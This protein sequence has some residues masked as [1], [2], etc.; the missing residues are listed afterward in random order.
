MY[1]DL[2]PEKTPPPGIWGEILTP[3]QLLCILR[4]IRPDRLVPA[5]TNFV[6][7]FRGEKYTE[8]PP[9]DL[10]ATF[11]DSNNLTPLIFILSPGTDPI[12]SISTFAATSSR[13]LDS[14]SLG[15][16]QG[17]IAERMI[18]EAMIIPK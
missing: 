15:Q 1:D 13:R 5:I 3:F 9:F 7:S 6:A 10:A 2:N 18:K 17:P 16:G 8:P 4:C 11:K 12:G 14:L